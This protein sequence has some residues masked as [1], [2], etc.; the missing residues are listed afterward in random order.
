MKTKLLLILSLVVPSLCF[1]ESVSVSIFENANGKDNIDLILFS[2]SIKKKVVNFK[3]YKG[4][5]YRKDNLYAF[6][7]LMKF[8]MD[9]AP[10]DIDFYFNDANCLE[11]F[12][13]AD[14]RLLFE[15]GFVYNDYAVT[16]QDIQAEYG[17]YRLMFYKP[18]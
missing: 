4:T 16:F 13:V 10:K 15:Y 5:V 2:T 7:H 17:R 12:Q 1:S 14:L 9:L 8:M 11:K 3:T 6:N 18:D